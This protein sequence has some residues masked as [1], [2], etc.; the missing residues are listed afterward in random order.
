MLKVGTMELMVQLS[1]DFPLNDVKIIGRRLSHLGCLAQGYIPAEIGMLEIPALKYSELEGIET[2]ILPDRNIVSRIATIAKTGARRPLKDPAQLACDL[3]AFAQA[4]NIE[5]DPLIAY[6]ELAYSK[7][8][9][10]AHDELAWFRSAD[11]AQAQAWIDIAQGR[12]DNLKF[13]NPGERTDEDLAQPIHRW[14]C[15]YVVTLKVAELELKE[16]LPVERTKALLDW[17]ID[18]FFLAGPAA[19]FASMYF[20]P[21]ARRR[22]LIKQLRSADRAKAI[23][24][25]KNAAW[26]MTYLSSFARRSQKG[27]Q[28]NRRYIFATADKSLA[29]IA[30]ILMVDAEDLGEFE[31]VMTSSLVDWWD[32]GDAQLI[33]QTLAA[34]IEI[35]NNR[36]PPG[37]NHPSDDPIGDWIA[38]GERRLLDWNG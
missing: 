13:S 5:F 6:H 34:H 38:A 22:N 2:V 25:A 17:M 33:A 11:Q 28:E 4:M 7:S 24:G 32:P 31:R 10:I 26:D 3:M 37:E 1:A 15:N 35:A 29:K 19:L 23:E 18:D 27:E 9:D 21:K 36:P 8:N 30:P 12:R 20:A 16:M 14:R